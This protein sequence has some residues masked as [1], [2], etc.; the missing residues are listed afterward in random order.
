MQCLLL[1]K[2]PVR[3]ITFLTLSNVGEFDIY[4]ETVLANHEIAKSVKIFS[5]FSYGDYRHNFFYQIWVDNLVTLS[6]KEDKSV[7]TCWPKMTTWAS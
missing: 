2:G 3:Q 7:D 4:A 5:V 1:L 6:L